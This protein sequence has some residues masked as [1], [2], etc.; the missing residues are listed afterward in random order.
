MLQPLHGVDRIGVVERHVHDGG[1]AA[2]SSGNGR[3]RQTFD[4]DG[5][6]GMNL[7]V[8]DARKHELAARVDNRTRRRRRADPDR[9]DLAAVDCQIAPF[10]DTVGQYQ[11]AAH[12]QFI[13]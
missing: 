12:K 10:E 9:V 2:G 4:T 5:A 13:H 6:S 11:I 7:P 8:D 1:D 3:I